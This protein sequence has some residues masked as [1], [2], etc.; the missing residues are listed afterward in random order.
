MAG[1]AKVSIDDGQDANAWRE[2]F[3]NGLMN[4]REHFG[5]RNRNWQR[6]TDQG[7][8]EDEYILTR[9]N[10]LAKQHNVP[11]SLILSKWGYQ[12]NNTPQNTAK[13]DSNTNQT[14]EPNT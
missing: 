13:P 2:D 6:E 12:A 7:F 10:A 11:V 9:A 4:R 14:K 1:P 3:A 5:N 8:A